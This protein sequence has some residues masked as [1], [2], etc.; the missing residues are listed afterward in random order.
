MT[1]HSTD[2]EDNPTITGGGTVAEEPPENAL[3]PVYRQLLDQ[4]RFGW[5][6]HH[7]LL[8]LLGR[9][10]Q[11]VVFLTERR[12]T[13]GFTLPV[14]L[15]VFSPERYRD[16]VAYEE[17]MYRI[18]TVAAQVAQIQHDHLVDVHN[19]VDR[20]RI[21]MMFMEWIDG[22][23]LRRLLCNERLDKV[24]DSVEPHIWE[25]L[26]S[27]VLAEGPVQPR[28]KAGV[29]VAIVRDCLAALAALH[30][31][32]IVHSDIKPANV[33]LNFTGSA[34]IIDIGSAFQI[35]NPPKQRSC[36][37]QYAAPEVLEGHEATPRSDLASLGYVLIEL[38]SG[39]PCFTSGLEL[40]ELLAEKRALPRRLEEILPEEVTVNRLLM[41]LC[42]G[43]IAPDPNLRFPTAEAADLREQGAAAF[44]RQL[45]LGNL[46]S[47]YQID[48]RTWL[49]AL[50]NVEF[51]EASLE[52]ADDSSEVSSAASS[53][54]ILPFP[55]GTT[56]EGDDLDQRFDF[57][58]QPGD[59]PPST[60]SI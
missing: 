4:R 50:R 22:Y 44:H 40:P 8:K 51:Q 13:D 10:G 17:A 29:A 46:A 31:E 48:I 59:D 14:A 3:A 39:S 55:G 24:R 53:D 36:T 54:A 56:S 19:F 27:V 26:H 38:L 12:G 28:L 33:M 43:L 60:N 7:Y 5:T 18:A 45:V 9:G 16:I 32:G 23:D 11:G 41:N 57:R 20:N 42:R 6:S 21:R 52:F 49:E 2:Y 1:S 35:T 37:P 47:E 34:K 58:Q 25:F 30:R 15:K